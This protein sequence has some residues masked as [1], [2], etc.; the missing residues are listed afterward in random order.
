MRPLR[1]FSARPGVLVDQ[2]SRSVSQ[3]MASPTGR[4]GRP[5]PFGRERVL[6]ALP[7]SETPAQWLKPHRATVDQRAAYPNDP[8]LPPSS[9]VGFQGVWVP[10]MLTARWTEDTRRMAG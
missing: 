4:V 8:S 7:L 5:G 9:M 2:R 6:F 3:S 10:R 1:K